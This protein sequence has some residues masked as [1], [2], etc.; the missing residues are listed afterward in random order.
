MPFVTQTN[1]LIITFGVF[2]SLD[3]LTGISHSRRTLTLIILIER[4]LCPMRPVRLFFYKCWSAT[5][6]FC[7]VLVVVIAAV[8]FID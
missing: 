1:V 3:N 5:T 6:L 4:A 7:Q 8:P 2:K